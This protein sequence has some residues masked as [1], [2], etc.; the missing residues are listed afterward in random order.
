MLRFKD[1]KKIIPR[2]ATLSNRINELEELKMIEAVPIKDGRRKFFAYRLTE[3]G[4]RTA[5]K[6]KEINSG[7]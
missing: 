6:L 1:L 5:K 4:E 7:F 3:K 2:E